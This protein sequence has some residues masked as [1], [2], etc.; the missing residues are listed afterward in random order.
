MVLTLSLIAN[1]VLL[2][3]YIRI[4]QSYHLLM[5]KNL[6]KEKSVDM[7]VEQVAFDTAKYENNKEQQLL[8]KLKEVEIN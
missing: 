5:K 7:L 8:Q 2:F 1:L 6:Q 3:L 4:R